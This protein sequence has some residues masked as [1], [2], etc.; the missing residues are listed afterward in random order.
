MIRIIDTYEDVN[1][2]FDSGNFNIDKWK[3]YINDIYND[4][5]DIF[6]TEMNDYIETGMYTYEKDFLPIINDVYKN[7][8]LDILHASF[9]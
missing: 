8:K 9:E 3:T 4:F 2:L 6:Q 5:A 1:C 7:P